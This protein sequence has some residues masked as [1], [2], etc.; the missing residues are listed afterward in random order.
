LNHPAIVSVY[1][2]GDEGD[3]A[4]MAMEMLEGRELREVMSGPRMPVALAVDIAAQVAEGLAY[5]HERGVV[6]RDIKPGNVMVLDGGRVKIMDFGIAR[7]RAS[8][9]KTQ[10]GLM[11]GSPKYMSP[12][13]IMGQPADHRSDVFSLGVVLYEMLAG[14]APF[15]GADIPQLMFQVCNAR[16]PAPSRLN[17]A[18]PEVLD[19]VVS[20]A[21]EKDLEARYQD[22]A[23]LAADLRRLAGELPP[24]PSPQAV[25]ASASA[26]RAPEA[27]QE[28]AAAATMA[29]T[30]AAPGPVLG[31]LPW[32]RFDSARALER[33]GN[34]RG[35]DRAL[36]APASAIGGLRR[37]LDT[38]RLAGAAILAGAAA[39]AAAI[40]YS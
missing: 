33:L 40:A 16:P 1:D 21:L 12:E 9:V 31:L 24:E 30:V 19:L 28:I 14:A 15:G 37:W 7:V 3:I 32:R 26:A 27:T 6:H 20:R 36:L 4:Y 22:A 35:L 34:P 17:P 25:A 13:Q 2:Y 18:I 10:T 38:T 29:A 11:L 23:V 8:D 5:A 39:L